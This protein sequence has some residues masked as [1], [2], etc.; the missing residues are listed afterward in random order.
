MSRNKNVSSKYRNGSI[1]V[2]RDKYLDKTAYFSP[3]HHM[4]LVVINK[5]SGSSSKKI[6]NFATNLYHRGNKIK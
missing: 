3:G 2:T 5:V 4:G 1:V 6:K